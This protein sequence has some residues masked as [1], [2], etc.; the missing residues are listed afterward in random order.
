MTHISV[1]VLNPA[2]EVEASYGV[3]AP[4]LADLNGKTIGLIDNRKSGAREFLSAIRSFLEKDFA[5]IRFVELSKGY[6][7]K[8]RIANFQEILRKMDA[9]IYST[10]D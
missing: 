10:G 9:A 6:G 7:E 5:G 1:E 3:P 4:R 2:G 8:D